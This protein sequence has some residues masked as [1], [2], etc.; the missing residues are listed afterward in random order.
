MILAFRRPC[1]DYRAALYAYVDRR[2]IEAGTAAALH[3]LDRCRDCE[4]ELADV[5]LAVHALARLRRELDAVEPPIDAWLR[6][7]ERVARPRNPWRWRASMGGLA[8]SALLVAVLV[9]PSTLSGTPTS[10]AGAV[11]PRPEVERRVEAEYLASIRTGTLPA[12]PRATYDAAGA[13]RMYPPEIAQVRKEVPA[14]P[15]TGRSLQPI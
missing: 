5:V 4:Q 11:V 13:M 8:S 14:A 6:L 3:H 10:E 7:R 2:E 1:A 15:A 9:L 12:T